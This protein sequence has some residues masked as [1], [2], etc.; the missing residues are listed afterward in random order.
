LSVSAPDV[1]TRLPEWP[2]ER[3][4]DLL[5]FSAYRFA[6]LTD[7][8]VIPPNAGKRVMEVVSSTPM[9]DTASEVKIPTQ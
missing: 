6:E 4:H 3:L 7:V 5:P 1:L 8:T 2:E 9:N